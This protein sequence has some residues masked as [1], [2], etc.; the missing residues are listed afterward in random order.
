[1][2]ITM[3]E[4][5]LLPEELRQLRK[6]IKFDF[7][8]L[9]ILRIGLAVI[10]GLFL[11][12]ICLGI[13]VKIASS[14]LTKARAVYQ[15][16]MPDKQRLDLVKAERFLVL[17]QIEKLGE[18]TQGGVQWTR[19]LSRLARLIN[20]GIWLTRLEVKEEL[21]QKTKEAIDPVTKRMVRQTIKVP[22]RR[23]EIHGRVISLAGEETAM[24]GKF[25]KNLKSDEE[26]F[27]H[28][29][30]IELETIQR[31]RIKDVE[32]MDFKFACYFKDETAQEY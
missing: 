22:R 4:I 3:L 9:P 14:R 24:V 6:E 8:N 18:F 28:F 21:L 12:Q 19:K 30:D 10:G 17:S 13:V 31:S 27:Q 11:V 23:L 25:I 2:I 7:G 15:E 29:S 26:F 5:N 32:V 16:L 1:M 20:P